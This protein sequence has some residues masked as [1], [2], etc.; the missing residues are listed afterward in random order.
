[1]THRNQLAALL[2]LTS[3]AATAHAA[4]TLDRSAP[5]S[6]EADSAVIDEPAGSAIYRGKVLLKQGNMRLQASELTLYVK[7]GRAQKAVASGTP[8]KLEQA[9]TPGSEATQAEAR[10]IT[11]LVTEDRMILETQARLRQGER[12]FQGAHI[13][14]ELTN[15]RVSASGGGDSRVLLVLPGTADEVDDKDGIDETAT[16][17]PPSPRKP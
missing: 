3:V 8:V 15:R 13:D 12:L 2:L 16:Q 11:F 5:I 10:R 1:M 17:A 9:A 7:D 14:Y 6:I 4:L